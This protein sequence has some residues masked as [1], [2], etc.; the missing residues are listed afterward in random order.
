MNQNME[1]W[2]HRMIQNGAAVK[3]ISKALVIAYWT[4]SRESDERPCFASYFSRK[5]YICFNV[6]YRGVEQ[7]EEVWSATYA[8]F[9]D[10]WGLVDSKDVEPVKFEMGQFSESIV[11]IKVLA[12]HGRQYTL[13]FR[14]SN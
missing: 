2:R 1:A 4:E 8:R 14:F 7:T 6:F 13:T 5:D 12:R 9:P 3:K 11:K 10:G